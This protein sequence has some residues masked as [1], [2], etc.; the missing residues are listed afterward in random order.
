MHVIEI[1]ALGEAKYFLQLLY[2]YVKSVTQK[3]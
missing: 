2:F 3:T 1:Q